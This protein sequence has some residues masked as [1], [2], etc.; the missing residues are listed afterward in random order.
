[1]TI[2]PDKTYTATMRTSCGDITIDLLAERRSEDGQQLRLPVR[3]RVL[4]R[5][6]LPTDRAGL[7]DPGRRPARQRHRRSR[8]RVRERGAQGRDLRQRRDPR[9]GQR[10][11]EHNGSQFF[12][13]L[14][15][16]DALRPEEYTIFGHVTDGQD[17]VD[18]IAKVTRGR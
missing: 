10:R 8:V 4:R 16:S 2:D 6:H 3:R 5:A 18:E 13:T 7:P 17:V 11:S 15:E 12:I 14:A 1:M 9:D